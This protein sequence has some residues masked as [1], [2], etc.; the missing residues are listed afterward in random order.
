MSDTPKNSVGRPARIQYVDLLIKGTSE[1][2][3]FIIERVPVE[4]AY[5]DAERWSSYEGVEEINILPA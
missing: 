3:S 1:E 2:D 4:K 5:R